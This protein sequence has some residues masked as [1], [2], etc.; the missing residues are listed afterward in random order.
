MVRRPGQGVMVRDE[1]E[2][3]KG[4]DVMRGDDKEAGRGEE[5]EGSG[6]VAEGEEGKEG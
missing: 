2:M 1:G 3:M 5:V 6:E 4:V